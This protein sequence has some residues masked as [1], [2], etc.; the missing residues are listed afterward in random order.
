[1][2][3]STNYW[4]ITAVFIKATILK[5]SKVVHSNWWKQS[6]FGSYSI[7][8]K[9]K[10]KK[11]KKTPQLRILDTAYADVTAVINNQ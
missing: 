1:M 5:A 2:A 11:K 7:I 4:V 10:K 6:L 9:K 3:L 8:R